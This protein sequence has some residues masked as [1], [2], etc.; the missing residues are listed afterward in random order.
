MKEITVFLSTHCFYERIILKQNMKKTILFLV[1]TSFCFLG[2]LCEAQNLKSLDK[3][4]VFA[5]QA[6]LESLKPN[7]K[8]IANFSFDDTQRFDWHFVPRERKGLSMKFMTTEQREKAMNLVKTALSQSG[9]LR[10]DQ[11]MDLENVLRVIENRPPNDLRRDPENY[12]I[13]IFGNPMDDQW[14]WRIEGHHLSLNFTMVNGNVAYTPSF[15]G[16]NPGTVLAEVPQKNR[17][18][19]QEEQMS[20]FELL[21]SL[22]SSQLKMAVLSDQAPND[23]VTFNNRRAEIEK[24]EGISY[25]E[26]S[27]PQQA[28][29]IKVIDAY[30]KRYHVSLEKQQWDNLKKHDLNKIFFSWMGDKSPLIGKGHGHYYRVHGPTFL[31]EFDNTQN[32]ANHIHAVVRDLENDFGDDLLKMHYEKS[33]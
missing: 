21:A 18:V 6:Y 7:E 15:F 9:M 20:G 33:H 4:M 28:L 22:N 24:F 10:V 13:S 27:K 16:S 26:L 29:L 11:I 19:L 23:V 25:G 8:L 17:N 31:I 3:A 12:A 1:L 5:A 30:L 32:D 2:T 14:A